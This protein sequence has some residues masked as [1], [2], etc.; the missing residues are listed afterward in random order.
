M[1]TPAREAEYTERL[2]QIYEHAKASRGGV[3]SVRVLL[4]A[5]QKDRALLALL[6]ECTDFS[7]QARHELYRQLFLALQKEERNKHDWARRRAGRAGAGGGAGDGAGDGA[8]V[9]RAMR[10]GRSKLATDAMVNDPELDGCHDSRS[11]GDNNNTSADGGTNQN[12]NL[13]DDVFNPDLSFAQV[14]ELLPTCT[15]GVTH[16]IFGTTLMQPFASSAVGEKEGKYGGPAASD[17]FGNDYDDKAMARTLT[18]TPDH[19]PNTPPSREEALRIAANKRTPEKRPPLGVRVLSGVRDLQSAAVERRLALSRTTQILNL[20]GCGL[21]RFPDLLPQALKE[22]KEVS[23][24]RNEIKMLPSELGYAVKIRRLNVACNLLTRVP[25]SVVRLPYLLSLDISDNRLDYLPAAIGDLTHL[26]VLAAGNNRLHSLPTGLG[27]LVQLEHLDLDENPKLH[28]VLRDKLKHSIPSL[29]AFL[30]SLAQA[31]LQAKDIVNGAIAEAAEEAKEQTAAAE[32]QATGASPN[33]EERKGKNVDS[34]KSVESNNNTVKKISDFES[35]PR[36]NE[37]LPGIDINKLGERDVYLSDKLMTMAEFGTVGRVVDVRRAVF[38]ARSELVSEARGVPLVLDHLGLVSLSDDVIP[39][40]PEVLAEI[41]S[42]SVNCNQLLSSLDSFRHILPRFH[43]LRRLSLRA[44]AIKRV[45]RSTE[46][47]MNELVALQSL[48]L[49]QNQISDIDAYAF[50]GLRRLQFLDVS[51]NRLNALP[52]TA[53]SAL[54]GLRALVIHCN[55]PGLE[56]NPKLLAAKRSGKGLP[57]ILG[58]LVAQEKGFVTGSMTRQIREDM[59]E[60]RLGVA[61]R[62]GVLDLSLVVEKGFEPDI[63]ADLVSTIK[64]LN[65][66]G[67]GLYRFPRAVSLMFR[68]TRLN[69]AENCLENGAFLKDR[70]QFGPGSPS[71]NVPTRPI[72]DAMKQLL[73]L[74]LSGNNLGPE[75]PLALMKL[76]PRLQV[77]M[78]DGNKLERINP[79]FAASKSSRWRET[80]KSISLRGNPLPGTVLEAVRQRGVPGLFAALLA[81]KDEEEIEAKRMHKMNMEFAEAAEREK[82]AML[83]RQ[84]KREQGMVQLREQKEEQK[85]DEREAQSVGGKI[86]EGKQNEGRG[87]EEAAEREAERLM[88]AAEDDA[89]A[90]EKAHAAEVSAGA[91]I[92]AEITVAADEEEEGEGEDAELAAPP[93]EAEVTA[94]AEEEAAVPAEGK[95]AAPAEEEAA[96][97]AE[98]KD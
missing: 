57:A 78:L 71:G 7:T 85:G 24:K 46:S 48:D 34:T 12:D 35:D 65:L 5:L 81:Q 61:R 17:E 45:P 56:E 90:E 96:A 73:V 91:P 4:D 88:K 82:H 51:E 36:N 2:L 47:G 87:G 10:G 75:L 28:P 20:D 44:C 37:F 63:P 97:P 84:R 55:G 89:A 64:D 50:A 62:I 21:K 30:Q 25:N 39:S 11:G 3:M 40:D 93:V 68:L 15:G 38:R 92:G 66:K 98:G 77:L 52:G 6:E 72:F 74:D 29:L 43:G 49:A 41:R 33:P 59:V 9:L 13:H 80:L 76:A 31:V 83:E 27:R 19:V 18:T 70:T 58:A 16:D 86:A 1:A 8:A 14:K 67:N 79:L 69:V 42:F 26:R 60:A 95:I 54:P 53:L 32:Q 22:L 94:P 23:V